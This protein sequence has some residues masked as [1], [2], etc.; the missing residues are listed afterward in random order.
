MEEIFAPERSYS[1]CM[2][3]LCSEMGDAVGYYLYETFWCVP[4]NSGLLFEM[5]E[6]NRKKKII[7]RTSFE[8]VEFGL[9]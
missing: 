2:R 1:L 7:I 9:I 6:S 8:N 3:S 5:S 4:A